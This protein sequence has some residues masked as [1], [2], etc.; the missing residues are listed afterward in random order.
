MNKKYFYEPSTL[1][2]Y[3][4]L[5]KL[6]GVRG[7]KHK[8]HVSGCLL[9]HDAYASHKPVRKT[10]ERNFYT[11][12]NLNDVW[13]LDPADLQNI[14]QYNPGIKYLLTCI[15]CFS[16][17]PH[18]KPLTSKSSMNAAKAFA[19]VL[20]DADPSK[21]LVLRTDRGKEWKYY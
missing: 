12:S 4:T 20:E 5:P 7:K 21:H 15:D 11:V 6:V 1:A 8:K 19:S 2:A 17:Y 18:I 16:R 10:F 9:K 3:S 13:D 14:E